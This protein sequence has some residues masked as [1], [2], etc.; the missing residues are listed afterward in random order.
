MALRAYVCGIRARYRTT[1]ISSNGLVGYCCDGAQSRHGNVHKWT[2]FVSLPSITRPLSRII[3]RVDYKL[4][5]TFSPSVKTVRAQTNF[6]F[7]AYGWGTFNVGCTIHW[8]A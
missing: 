2:M 5:P 1:I 8:N 4:H 7:T 3:E 6:E